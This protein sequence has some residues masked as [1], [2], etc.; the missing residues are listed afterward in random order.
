MTEIISLSNFWSMMLGILS[1]SGA[2]NDVALWMKLKTFSFIIFGIVINF[3]YVVLII[4]LISIS[5]IAGKNRIASISAFVLNV[6]TIIFSCISVLG[7]R[8]AS[9]LLESRSICSRE[10]GL[11]P[12]TK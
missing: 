11:E 3:K 10:L 4:S 1:K 9:F 12:M 6:V 8:S 5:I 7:N 2:L